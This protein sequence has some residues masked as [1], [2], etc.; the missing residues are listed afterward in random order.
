MFQNLLHIFGKVKKIHGVNVLQKQGIAYENI[1]VKSVSQ[2][3]LYMYIIFS[4]SRND[5][6][7]DMISK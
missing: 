1:D 2:S 6:S 3:K 7:V 4:L 5:R